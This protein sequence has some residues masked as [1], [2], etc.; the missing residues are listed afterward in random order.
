MPERRDSQAVHGGGG[1]AL[2]GSAV[3]IE[4]FYQD[5]QV[6]EL[7]AFE[8][9]YGNAFLMVTAAGL[10]GPKSS[11]GT[12][13]LLDGVDD[14][15]GERTAV[16]A[17]V[18]YPLRPKDG[19][20]GHLVTLGRDTRHDVVV[21]GPSVSRFHAFAKRGPDGSFLLQDMGS[22]NGTSVNG[23]SVPARGAGP[24]R[25]LK[26]GDTVKFGQVEFTYTDARALREYALQAA[27]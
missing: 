23:V 17:V 2:P 18:I 13:L 19:S 5:A 14:D 16:L 12:D 6:L 10:G 15:P 27:G 25:P 11:S 7:E 21:P 22:T 1:E 26:P 24:P 4:A 20:A 8:A 9:R 3:P